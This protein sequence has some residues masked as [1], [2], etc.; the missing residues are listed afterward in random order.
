MDPFSLSRRQFLMGAGALSGVTLTSAGA[1][2]PK[3]ALGPSSKL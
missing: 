2:L 1:Y 3:M